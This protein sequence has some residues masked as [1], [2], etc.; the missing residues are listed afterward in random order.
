MTSYAENLNSEAASNGSTTRNAIFWIIAVG[1]LAHWPALISDS[2]MWDDWIVL[3][4]IIQS[5][6]DWLYHFYSSFGVTPYFIVHYPFITLTQNAATAIIIAKIIFF[7]GVILDAILVM[8]ISKR[9]AHGNMT[10]AL[11]AGIFA[12]CFPTISGEGFHI[13][14][15]VY[16][17]FI[18]LFLIGLYLF[19]AI[20]SSTKRHIVIRILALAIL[21]VSFTLNS[22]LVM[23]YAI[24]PA[25]FYASL[26][27]KVQN[28]RNLS[29][30]AVTFCIRNIDFLLIPLIYW[31]FKERY[32]PRLGM[33]SGYNRVLFNDWQGTLYAYKALLPEMLQSTLFV[34]LSIA[35]VP[36]ITGA[37][38]L[39][40]T[41]SGR[42]ILKRIEVSSDQTKSQLILLFIFGLIVLCGAA[43]PY[44][45]VG[46][47][48]FFAYGYL[49]R[50]SNL[51]P[52]PISWMTAALFCLFLKSGILLWRRAVVGLMVAL[53]AAQCI[54]NWRNH[55]DWQA[56]YAY[57]RSAMEKIHDDKLVREAS[58]IN[59]IDQIP[60]DRSLKAW[61]YPT[62]I[63][64]EIISDTFKKT[65]RLAI[66]FPP[67]NGR[68]YT[69]E[70]L[71]QRLKETAIDY[72]LGD[73]NLNGKQIQ[74]SI[75][76]GNGARSPIRLALTY[77]HARFIAPADMPKLLDS[78]TDIKTI[79]I[80]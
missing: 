61:K 23:F 35:F 3:S 52:L 53:I 54:S 22:A 62:S 69:E 76:P 7:S 12:V 63:W 65:N 36:L 79:P 80:N 33:Y 17:I 27:S 75:V 59:V 60:G 40:V 55:A 21:F 13:S 44:Y 67:A 5:R 43:F 74:L 41:F 10:F 56:L 70:E 11:L 25:I 34:P 31:W 26:Q 46:R 51:F 73:I 4:S 68:F 18:P 58:V 24:I 39:V 29:Q 72:M 15:I 50:D 77:W 42:S 45:A 49:S 64:T 30:R 9:V 78:L 32:M 28:I 16:P 48:T 8:L 14:S 1:I 37:I 19:I 71:K 47:R 57:H 66:P 38:F 20:A 2:I 6:P